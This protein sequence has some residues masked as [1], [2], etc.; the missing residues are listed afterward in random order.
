LANRAQ[1]RFSV[2]LVR[3]FE[4]PRDTGRREIRHATERR[5]A[6]PRRAETARVA[7]RPSERVGSVPPTRMQRALDRPDG[8]PAKRR[9]GAERRLQRRSLSIQRP[10]ARGRRQERRGE[11]RRRYRETEVR[12]ARAPRVAAGFGLLGASRRVSFRPQFF[13]RT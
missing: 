8:D 11:K 5:E 13:S 3:L 10:C 7:E 9:L 6:Y 2:G 1:Y 12:S 4:R